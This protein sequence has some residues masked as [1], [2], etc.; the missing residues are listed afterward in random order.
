MNTIIQKTKDFLK[1]S[2]IKNPSYSFNNWK[3]MYEHGTMVLT[4]SLKI[5]RE[6]ANYDELVLS[7]AALLHDIGKTYQADKQTLYEKHE[8]FSYLVSQKFLESLDLTK[9]QKLKLKEILSDPGKSIEKQIIEDADIIAFLADKRLQDS[10]KKW[11]DQEGLP[12]EM[13]RKL[14]KIN[15]LKFDVS[16][17]IAEPFYQ[18]VKRRFN[19]M[20]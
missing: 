13:K 19:I 4:F 9:E 20:V 11:A 1:E 17:K 7:I 18:S 5:A 10:F 2:F 15:L 12:H 3:I 14:D 6:M 16:K 8:E